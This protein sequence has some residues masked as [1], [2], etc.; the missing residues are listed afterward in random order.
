MDLMA[1]I[2]NLKKKRQ[3]IKDFNFTKAFSSDFQMR[4]VIST[5][6]GDRTLAALAQK[7]GTDKGAINFQ[8][9]P[10]D[11]LPHN[12]ADYYNSLLAPYRETFTTV[13]EMGIGST[14]STIP[15]NMGPL[16]IPGASLRMW[17]DFLPNANIY[18]GDIDPT[19]LIKEERID[20]S[21]CDVTDAISV[22]KFFSV[23]KL[24][25]IDLMIDDSLHTF[26]AG[27][28]L[29]ENSIHLI[30]PLGIY[31]I[32]DVTQSDLL[33][34]KEYFIKKQYSVEFVNLFRSYKRLYDNNLIVVRK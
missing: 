33:L 16:G 23:L 11:W 8:N 9:L 21:Q 22:R 18:G 25:K 14:D 20:S 24:A 27:I 10:Y 5:I 7:Y 26:K 4:S 29:F 2:R 3:N 1:K 13:V 32:E 28:N 6:H 17:R 31:I 19:V 30:S 15:D 12:Y 34:Y